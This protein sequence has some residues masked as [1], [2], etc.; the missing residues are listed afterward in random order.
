MSA[1]TMEISW[2]H[3]YGIVEKLSLLTGLWPFL[4]PGTRVIRVGFVALMA[5][6]MLIP[7][8]KQGRDA[9][10]AD[11]TYCKTKKITHFF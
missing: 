10:R 4:R 3:Y 6:T 8:V 1:K 11:G 2:S 5:V 9:Q 7:E